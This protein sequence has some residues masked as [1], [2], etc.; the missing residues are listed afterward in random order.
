MS[1]WKDLHDKPEEVTMVPSLE[2]FEQ[3][4]DEQLDDAQKAFRERITKEE[5]RL[6]DACDCN[7]Y[8]TV[9]FQNSAQLYE[10]CDKFGIDRDL[11]YVD[12]RELAKQFNKAL[13][14]KDMAFPKIQQFNKDY[15]A[16]ARE[17][18]P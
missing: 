5:K 15:V 2:D 12:G 4:M 17:F 18:Q 10:F 9:F 6:K 14:T 16:R 13:E 1:K 3:E 7:Y 8:F 11:L